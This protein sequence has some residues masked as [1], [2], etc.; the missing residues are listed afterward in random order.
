MRVNK[1]QIT[2]LVFLL[3]LTL[4][5]VSFVKAYAVSSAYY[6]EN[7]MRISPGDTLEFKML[8]QNLAS[9]ED[10]T[11][12]ARITSGAEVISLVDSSDIYL[13]PG[14]DKKEVNLRATVPSDA[15][16]GSVYNFDISFTTV[17]GEGQGTLNIGSSIGKKFNIEIIERP[18]QQV[19]DESVSDG[20]NNNS[21]TI[22]WIVLLI[23][24]ILGAWTFIKKKTG[25]KK[26]R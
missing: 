19:S 20:E 7:P 5:M 3:V 18:S 12:Q 11:V 10:V 21:S 15:S 13:I 22:F 2:G 23:I 8:L 4:L 9:D 25:S 24:V 26:S 1:K 17:A 6:E 16:I 14:G